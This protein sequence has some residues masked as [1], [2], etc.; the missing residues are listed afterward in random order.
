MQCMYNTHGG[1]KGPRSRGPQ[2]TTVNNPWKNTRSPA[3]PHAGMDQ[4]R[5]ATPP[6][7][8]LNALLCPSCGAPRAR[9]QSARAA[10][11]AVTRP[12]GPRVKTMRAWKPRSGA[13]HA[14]GSGAWRRRA[15]RRLRRAAGEDGGV[16]RSVPGLGCQLCHFSPALPFRSLLVAGRWPCGRSRSAPSRT[17]GSSCNEPGSRSCGLARDRRPGP[18][19]AV[20]GGG[21]C[22]RVGCTPAGWGPGGSRGTHAGLS[23]AGPTVGRRTRCEGEEV[24]GGRVPTSPTQVLG[25]RGVLGRGGGPVLRDSPC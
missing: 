22:S 17:P 16:H 11:P 23:G 25:V 9:G 3:A 21:S 5:L 10:P 20:G 2:R 19:S 13:G 7:L 12:R 14:P 4:A 15:C 8:S 18:G 1:S 6:G 24:H